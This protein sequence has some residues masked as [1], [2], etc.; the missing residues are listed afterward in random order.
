MLVKNEWRQAL[1]TDN[2]TYTHL[3]MADPILLTTVGTETHT[4]R[5]KQ[6]G[7]DK[8][9]NKS[10]TYKYKKYFRRLT[11]NLDFL[12]CQCSGISFR[13]F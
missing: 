7:T 6:R 3:G 11:I 2:Y 13:P 1:C 4:V 10:L 5:C 8:Q 12:E 9:K